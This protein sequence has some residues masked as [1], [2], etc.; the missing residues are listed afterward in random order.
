V[1]CPGRRALLDCRA[2]LCPATYACSAG[3]DLASS[4][5]CCSTPVLHPLP[6]RPS[7]PHQ[8]FNMI[9]ARKIGNEYNVFAGI[10]ASHIFWAVWVLCVAFQVGGRL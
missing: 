4:A 7:H 8:M 6:P 9:N 5:L 1:G 2:Q 10:F 3:V